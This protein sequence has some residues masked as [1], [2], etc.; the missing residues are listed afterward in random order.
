MNLS[1]QEV[2]TELDN[3][4]KRHFLRTVSGLVTELRNMSSAFVTQNLVI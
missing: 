3:L 2:Q 4:V 1:E